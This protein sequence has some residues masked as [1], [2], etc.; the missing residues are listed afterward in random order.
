MS[1]PTL[2]DHCCKNLAVYCDNKSDA[3]FSNPLIPHAVKKHIL[4]FSGWYI[5]E[6]NSLSPKKFIFLK[7][8][9]I[10][11]KIRDIQINIFN[12]PNNQRLVVKTSTLKSETYFQIIETAQISNKYI[13]LFDSFYAAFPKDQ[14]GLCTVDIVK[15]RCSRL[16]GELFEYY[17][18][19]PLIYYNHY[20]T[21][22]DLFQ[23]IN[24]SLN[25][26]QQVDD[27]AENVRG[28]M[29]SQFLS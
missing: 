1:I 29:N 7:N 12:H 27:S 4:N 6:E 21:S 13:Y 22:E 14:N 18:D 26:L 28:Y 11:L 24:Q 8:S 3:I 9:E 15:N 2:V 16:S 23:K 19:F 25:I 17:L 10:N 5:A 20:E